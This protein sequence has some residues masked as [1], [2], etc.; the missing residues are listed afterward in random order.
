MAIQEKAELYRDAKG[1]WRVQ[2]LN[3]KKSD[4]GMVV[5]PSLRSKLTDAHDGVIVRV[6]KVNGQIKR[7]LFEDG[8]VQEVV[9]QGAHQM[10]ESEK[11]HQRTTQE[12]LASPMSHDY[13]LL[14]TTVF[15]YDCAKDALRLGGAY[16]EYKNHA[17]SLPMM[18]RTNGLGATMAYLESKDERYFKELRNNIRGFLKQK[19][20]ELNEDEYFKDSYTVKELT[21]A[22]LTFVGWLRHFSSGLI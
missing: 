5:P 16:N 3:A 18:I 19:E 20:P 15:A 4:K 17:K 7:L 10:Q 13:S 2:A 21:K 6:V 9:K 12:N 11:S 14:S 1:L 8:D 22:V